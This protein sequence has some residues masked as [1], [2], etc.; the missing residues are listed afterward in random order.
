MAGFYATNPAAVIAGSG[1]P[2]GMARPSEGGCT[3]ADWWI[4]ADIVDSTR[5]RHLCFV[6]IPTDADLID[7]TWHTVRRHLEAPMSDVVAPVR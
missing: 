1:V 6:L 7:V 4:L 3:A 5:P 2:E